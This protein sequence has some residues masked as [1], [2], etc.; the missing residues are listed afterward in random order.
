MVG[1]TCAGVRL[2]LEA[3]ASN[4]GSLILQALASGEY[5]VTTIPVNLA[6]VP[7]R[8]EARA[9]GCRSVRGGLSSEGFQFA[10]TL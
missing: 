9:S 7:E 6:R 3:M 10:F 1:R 5:A 2:Y 8:A 4:S